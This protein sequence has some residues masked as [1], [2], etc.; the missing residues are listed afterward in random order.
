MYEY[1]CRQ[2]CD[3]LFLCY[4]LVWFHGHDISWNVLSL[5]RTNRIS[6]THTWVTKKQKQVTKYEW[7]NWVSLKNRAVDPMYP[8]YRASKCEY[9]LDDIKKAVT[10]FFLFCFC[11]IP[12]I[13]SFFSLLGIHTSLS[14]IHKKNQLRH[15]QLL[16]WPCQAVS[17][18]F[19]NVRTETNPIYVLTKMVAPMEDKL[20]RR[21]THNDYTI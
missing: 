13:Y 12:F 3:S 6:N 9:N 10:F 7:N 14:S 19:R 11:F 18:Q 21:Q 5:M 4:C 20:D 1:V 15:I 16:K 2:F 8:N 17:L